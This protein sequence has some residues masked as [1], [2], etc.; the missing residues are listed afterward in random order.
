MS[1][2]SVECA[3]CSTHLTGVEYSNT[4]LY[5][6]GVHRPASLYKTH[7]ISLLKWTTF[8]LNFLCCNIQLISLSYL[9]YW[10]YEKNQNQIKQF[11]SHRIK[12]LRLKTGV[13]IFWWKVD[14]KVYKYALNNGPKSAIILHYI[15]FI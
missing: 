1:H 4:V 6:L 14:P 10:K 7:R 5:P 9:F 15:V 13:V 12:I 8:Q 3:Y 11:Y 2:H